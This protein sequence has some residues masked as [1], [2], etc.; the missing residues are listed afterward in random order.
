ML[1]IR[2]KRAPVRPGAV[3]SI[4][5]KICDRFLY[6]E[7][8][9]AV[10]SGWVEASGLSSA[11]VARRA[12]VSTSTMH[13]I[14]N[15]LVD[16]AVGTLREIAFA[17]GVQLDLG[18]Q[19]LSDPGAASAARVMLESGYESPSDP[20][21]AS[22]RKR[23]AR[24]AGDDDPVEIVRAAADASRPLHRPGAVLF[25]GV[26]PLARIASAGDAA[27]GEW[28]VS[29]A[30]GLYLPPSSAPAPAVTILWCEDARTV[31]HLLGDTDLRP[32]K[33]PERATLAVIEAERE[34]FAGSFAEGIVR[35]AAPI[36]IML[37]CLAQS[38][39]VAGD[40]LEEVMSW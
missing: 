31:T 30:A 6:M 26:I 14:L 23:L 37:D 34:L 17:C 33:Y 11:A 21:V 8:L 22:W 3:H 18:T 15:D 25:R 2:L 24:M 9:P 7:S 28:A 19:P 10:V 12:G 32:A 1:E 4:Y 38:S 39:E 20:E 5:G 36:Q 16:P 27:K 35:Y 13:R 29:G 40:A